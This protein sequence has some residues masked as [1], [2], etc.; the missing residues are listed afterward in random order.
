MK[1]IFAIMKDD[2]KKGTIAV[3]LV[4]WASTATIFAIHAS[5]TLD[6][7]YVFI[8][9]C[10]DPGIDSEYTVAS[11]ISKNC[12]TYL[13]E[14]F[15]NKFFLVCEN[16]DYKDFVERYKKDCVYMYTR[17]WLAQ[18]R[19]EFYSMEE[20]IMR[21]QIVK[22]S[23]IMTRTRLNTSGI[24]YRISVNTNVLKRIVDEKSQKLIPVL[25]PTTKTY[26]LTLV[27]V[28]RSKNNAFGYK[29]SELIADNG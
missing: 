9:G 29:I 19:A 26:I 3:L 8:P 5:S 11:S 4:L 14:A 1:K 28:K 18:K 16:Y 13:E 12:K 27:E 21:L 17:E 24:K 25:E 2:I 22:S 15:I 7:K 10:S 20:S 23:E 6:E